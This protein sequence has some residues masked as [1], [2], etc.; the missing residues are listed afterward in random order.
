MPSP[1]HWFNERKQRWAELIAAAEPTATPA[2]VPFEDCGD[3]Y[4]LITLEDGRR[5]KVRTSTSRCPYCESPTTVH[6][7][8]PAPD[9]IEPE[10]AQPDA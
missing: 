2:L 3:G 5:F 1:P 9:R 4:F 6:H 10:K 7:C 8:R